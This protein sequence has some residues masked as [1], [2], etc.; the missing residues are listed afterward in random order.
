MQS[1]ASLWQLLCFVISLC[2]T[3]ARSEV[4][5]SFFVSGCGESPWEAGYLYVSGIR[6]PGRIIAW[7]PRFRLYRLT[8]T[9]SSTR[10]CF[11]EWGP[12]VVTLTGPQ[13]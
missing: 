12:C 11:V 1:T 6:A 13:S 7:P 8:V 2:R 3:K 5:A 4:L 10:R 9:S